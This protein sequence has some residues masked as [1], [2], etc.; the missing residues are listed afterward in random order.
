MDRVSYKRRIE[1]ELKLR[2]YDNLENEQFKEFMRHQENAV[3]LEGKIKILKST[4]DN[5]R[6]LE[7]LTSD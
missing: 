6:P 4:Q 3:I 1:L 7:I 2:Q 5:L